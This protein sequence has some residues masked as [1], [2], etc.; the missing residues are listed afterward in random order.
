[1]ALQSLITL[2]ATIAE[3]IAQD[4]G[5]KSQNIEKSKLITLLDG[6]GLGLASKVWQDSVSQ[7]QSVNNDLDLSG[8]LAGAFGAVVFTAV[9]GIIVIAGDSNP[10][11][12]VIGNVTN[13]IV[14]P[15]GAATHSMAVAPGG[16]FANINPS[17]AGFGV[18]ASTADLLRIASAATVGTYTY[19]V[20][21]IG[22]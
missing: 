14:A 7:A 19:D 17:A 21:I 5:S 1:M 20:V 6:T 15:F 8:S 16:I 11:N 12:L 4:L 2:R 22:I 9:K 13:G 3:A 18:T 10:G